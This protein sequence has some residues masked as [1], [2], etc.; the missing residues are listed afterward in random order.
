M[1]RY[2]YEIHHVPG[3]ELNTTHYLSRSPLPTTEDFD[4]ATKTEAY[5]NLIC[6]P[7][8]DRRLKEIQAAQDEDAKLLELKSELLHQKRGR[9]KRRAVTYLSINN[10]LIMRGIKVVIPKKLMY[11]QLFTQCV[12]I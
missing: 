10:G 7:I 9:R 11:I 5:I 6:L 3:K 8:T 12:C 1:M 4:L 2:L